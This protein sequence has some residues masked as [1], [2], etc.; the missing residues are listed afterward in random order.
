MDPSLAVRTQQVPRGGVDAVEQK[1]VPNARDRAR[2]GA[3]R[4]LIRAFLFRYA[5]TTRASPF[6]RSDRQSV[7]IDVVR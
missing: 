1:T 4:I 3:M 7:G 2:N 5:T 6:V